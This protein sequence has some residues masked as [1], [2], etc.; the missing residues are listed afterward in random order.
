MASQPPIG[1]YFFLTLNCDATMNN[2]IKSPNEYRERSRYIISP[3]NKKAAAIIMRDLADISREYRKKIK[4]LN[5]KM[6]SLLDPPK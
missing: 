2:E 1:H 5:D 3:A 6:A 4:A